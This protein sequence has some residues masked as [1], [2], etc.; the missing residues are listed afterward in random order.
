MNVHS[1]LSLERRGDEDGKRRDDS[2][3]ERKTV[4]HIC[5]TLIFKL[6]SI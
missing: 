3:G 2:R 5:Y 6:L 4:L 1:Y